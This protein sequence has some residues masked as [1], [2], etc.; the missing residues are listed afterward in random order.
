MLLLNPQI[1][2]GLPC[3]SYAQKPYMWLHNSTMLVA[4]YEIQCNQIFSIIRDSTNV[5]NQIEQ[6]ARHSIYQFE[7]HTQLIILILY[8]L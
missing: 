2:K 3:G 8:E 7:T 1:I 4:I 5:K 6:N